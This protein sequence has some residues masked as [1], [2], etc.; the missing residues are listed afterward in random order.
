MSLKSYSPKT[1]LVKINQRISTFTKVDVEYDEAR[2]NF[3]TAATGEPTR[4]QNASKLGKITL[5]LPQTSEDNETLSALVDD[6]AYIGA[7]D[8][9]TTI[10]ATIQVT[11]ED[12]WGNSRYVMPKGT[13][14]Q[15]KGSSF[16]A[17]P[18]D[19]DWEIQ[20]DITVFETGGN[21]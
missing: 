3:T 13:V 19:R 5:S 4:T 15:R 11:I 9:A 21:N 8:G 16:G 18:N 7:D 6:V 14:L 17:D 10:P 2:W 20:G 1:V 12:L